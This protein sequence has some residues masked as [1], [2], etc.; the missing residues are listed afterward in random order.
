MLVAIIIEEHKPL[1]LYPVVLF[2]SFGLCMCYVANV[3]MFAV[4]KGFHVGECHISIP[5]N[6]SSVYRLFV[7]L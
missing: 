2:G 6:M 5:M 4:V 1:S 7:L 3:E